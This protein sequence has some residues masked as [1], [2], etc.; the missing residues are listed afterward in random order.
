M[1]EHYFVSNGLGWATAE[2]LDEAIDRLWHARHTDVRNWLKNAQKDGQL[3]L[4]FYC[5]KVPLPKDAEYS[6]SW[7]APEVEGLTECQNRILTY[8]TQ[9]KIAHA[10]DPTDQIRRLE[11]ELNE[12]KGNDYS[13]VD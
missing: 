5:C 2:T 8:Y 1:S 13:E 3:G 9:K 11:N 12:L 10:A 6:I 4:P 7:Y